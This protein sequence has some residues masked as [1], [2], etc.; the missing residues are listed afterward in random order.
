VTAPHFFVS[1]LADVQPGGSVRLSSE[2]SRHALRSLRLRPG[3][4]VTLADGSGWF[5][6][7]GIRANDGALAVVEVLELEFA[8]QPSPRVLV[9][10]AP[11]KSDR[12]AWAVQKLAEVGVDELLLLADTER[13]VRR[14]KQGDRE[15]IAEGRLQRVAREAAMQSR[16]RFVMDVGWTTLEQAT[17]PAT[18]RVFLLWEGATEPLGW[19]PADGS[20]DLVRVVVGPEGGFS[21]V[22]VEQAAVA[23]VRPVSL[24]P[25]ILRTETAALAGAILV[26]GR[27]GR[28]GR[29]GWLG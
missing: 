26:L 1:S 3:E 13:A 19:D 27:L 24:G 23:G 17:D 4:D 22:E 29:L 18:G 12:L 8:E 5:A 20:A 6:R 11:P 9:A 16:R 10:M 7:G 21:E 15:R 14:P 25:A 28:L 2:D